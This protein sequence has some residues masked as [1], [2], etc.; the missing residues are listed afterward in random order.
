MYKNGISSKHTRYVMDEEHSCNEP[1]AR[2]GIKYPP[3]YIDPPDLLFVDCKQLLLS[4][5]ATTTGG[6][7]YIPGHGSVI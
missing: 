6:R 4:K 5:M 3:L 2:M 1:E 7:P